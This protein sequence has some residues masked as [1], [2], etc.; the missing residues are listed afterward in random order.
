M[1]AY[2]DDEW[3]VPLRD[4]RALFG[5]LVLDGFQ[6]GL[7]WRTILHKRDHFRRAFHDWDPERIARYGTRDLARLCKDPGIIRNKQK[8]DSAVKNARAWLK[9]QETG[10]FS[11][12]LWSFT[13]GATRHNRWSTIKQLPAESAE[14]RAMSKALKDLG[15]GFCGPTICYAFMQAVGMVNDHLTSCYRHAE[16]ARK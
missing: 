9:Y 4:D 7:S 14:S 6:A 15:F 8:I 12:L 16:L 3:G 11:E 13:G 1:I 2:H 5:K 10:S